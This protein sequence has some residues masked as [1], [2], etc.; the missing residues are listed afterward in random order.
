M[1]DKKNMISI[2]LNRIYRAIKIDVDL[3]EEVE[4]DKSAAQRLPNGNTLITESHCGRLFE[5]TRDGEIV[6][7]FINPHNL[8]ARDGLFFSDIFRGYRYRYDWVPQLDQPDER[9]IVPPT[10]DEFRIA[11]VTG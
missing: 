6:W 8:A 11:P 4:A 1:E 10:H 9:A 7:E 2:F 3:Y 5:V